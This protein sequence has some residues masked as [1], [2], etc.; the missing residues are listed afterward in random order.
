MI[1]KL[2]IFDWSG[3]LSPDAGT[4]AEDENLT[5][6]LGRS[7]L[8]A[9]GIGDPETFWN[10]IVN[11]TWQEGSTTP[12]GYGEVIF[13][14]SRRMSPHTVSDEE[15][16]LSA[17]RFVDSYLTHS[18]IDDRWR[19][20]LEK[21]GEDTSVMTVIATD[22]YAEATGYIVRYL[23]ELG[24]GAML[25]KDTPGASPFVVANSADMGAHKADQPFWDTLKGALGLDGLRSVMIVDD[26]GFNE[27]AGDTYADRQKV[28]DRKGA[29]LS[30]LGGVFG[31][32]VQSVPFVWERG[33]N[34]EDNK[35]TLD[36]LIA[37]ASGAIGGYLSEK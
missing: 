3:T 8:T 21:L 29:T 34:P 24:A 26:F 19:P 28:E 5:E 37:R 16:R 27:D 30:L 31:V 20:I 13:R 32:P 11:P 25:L 15:I 23:G 14:R 33:G 2:V 12:I 4:F 9:L 36:D 7:G 6:E 35:K 18:S 1:E 10:E 17:A 22:H